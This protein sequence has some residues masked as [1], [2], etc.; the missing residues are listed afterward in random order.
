MDGGSQAISA[1]DGLWAY[2]GDLLPAG[3]GVGAWLR[4]AVLG[5][6]L[7]QARRR[8]SQLVVC[9]R[10]SAIWGKSVQFEAGASVNLATTLSAIVCVAFSI[11][12]APSMNG[13]R[14]KKQFLALR[15]K[16]HNAAER[17]RAPVLQARLQRERRHERLAEPRPS[18]CGNERMISHLGSSGANSMSAAKAEKPA[19]NVRSIPFW[20]GCGRPLSRISRKTNRT[21][22]DDMLP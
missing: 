19:P 13:W 16:T 2:G 7:Q 18:V 5:L 11:A 4:R 9:Q 17:V 12:R 8:L 6:A 20:P 22:G 14:V 10:S 3:L 21:D 1:G 15:H